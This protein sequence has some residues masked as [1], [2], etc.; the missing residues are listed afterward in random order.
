MSSPSQSTFATTIPVVVKSPNSGPQGGEITLALGS[1]DIN[2]LAPSPYSGFDVGFYVNG[3][4]RAYT[5]VDYSASPAPNGIWQVALLPGDTGPNG[6]VTLTVASGNAAQTTDYQTP[7]AKAAPYTTAPLTNTVLSYYPM[8]A[9][10]TSTTSSPDAYANNGNSSPGANNLEFTGG[11]TRGAS[12]CYVD[13]TTNL[14]PGTSATFDGITGYAATNAAVTNQLFGAVGY[15]SYTEDFTFSVPSL[16]GGG[17]L[18]S[19]QGV[20]TKIG[21]NSSGLL[22]FYCQ[23]VPTLTATVAIAGATDYK[24]TLTTN[25]AFSYVWLD[26]ELI[27][28]GEGNL[29]IYPQATSTGAK[30]FYGADVTQ[31][32]LQTF[33][34]NGSPTGGTFTITVPWGGVEK[35]ATITYP[36]SHASMQTTLTALSNVGS[37]NLLLTGT[38]SATVTVAPQGALA[39]T[40]CGTL[41]ISQTGLTGGTASSSSATITNTAPL[42]AMTID[43][44]TKLC[45]TTM[46]EE[47]LA[48]YNQAYPPIGQS[49]YLKLNRIGSGSTQG[50]FLTAPASG[51]GSLVGGVGGFNEFC[52]IYFPGG[53]QTGLGLIYGVACVSDLARYQIGLVIL[54]APDFTN[55][56]NWK[57]QS[58]QYIGG[59][60]SITGDSGIVS[61]ETPSG[62]AVAGN[63][64]W[65]ATAGFVLSYGNYFGD[66]AIQCDTSPDLVNWSGPFTLVAAGSLINVISPG[67]GWG[68]YANHRIGYT[69]ASSGGASNGYVMILEAGGNGNAASGTYA[70][71]TGTSLVAGGNLAYNA[72]MSNAFLTFF[73]N[74]FG[75]L[76]APATPAMIQDPASNNTWFTAAGANS[77]VVFNTD[78]VNFTT[79]TVSPNMLYEAA[80]A[81]EVSSATIPVNFNPTGVADYRFLY[82]NGIFGIFGACNGNQTTSVG[83]IELATYAGT[84]LQLFSPGSVLETAGAQTTV[85]VGGS[86]GGDSNSIG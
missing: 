18:W 2:P 82:A 76:F 63:I 35:T 40:P 47:P 32:G 86:I 7:L 49:S 71:L 15:Q 83:I 44:I 54:T 9:G 13:G 43:N 69:Y 20:P 16:A 28:S 5:R 53:M 11:V 79:F 78:T 33:H 1:A 55:P 25:N 75:S 68:N 60:G 21:Y 29:G 42:T 85:F 84:P 31:T 10:D 23:G 3:S 46:P 65:D 62:G 39:Y 77:C 59:S 64:H 12:I 26:G 50:Q 66:Y 41:I 8:L 22:S 6:L 52:P 38:V 48:G 58:T 67:V 51:F 30:H 27:L 36:S 81:Y 4:W 70:F 37:G 24:L 72:T 73:D 80:M 45:R 56:A 57:V 17:T 14:C 19:V 34:L 74:E 61:A